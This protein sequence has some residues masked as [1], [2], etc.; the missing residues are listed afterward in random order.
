MFHTVRFIKVDHWRVKLKNTKGQASMHTWTTKKVIFLN[1]TE[2]E[3]EK[4]LYYEHSQ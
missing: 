4:G 1:K 2:F 3:S